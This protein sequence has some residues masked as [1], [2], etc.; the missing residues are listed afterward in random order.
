MDIQ[1]KLIAPEVNRMRRAQMMP[2]VPYANTDDASLV[3]A[4]QGIA[5]NMN[6]LSNVASSFAKLEQETQINIDNNALNLA[7]TNSRAFVQSFKPK[8]NDD[9]VKLEI[10]SIIAQQKTY[11]YNLTK[12]GLSSRAVERLNLNTQSLEE[13][14][15]IRQKFGRMELAE[16]QAQEI[17]MSNLD[18]AVKHGNPDAAEQ[19]IAE[20]EK[21]GY[22]LKQSRDEYISS[23]VMQQKI[24]NV[25]YDPRVD[26]R[27]LQGIYETL[28]DVTPEGQSLIYKDDKSGI[29][30]SA[31]DV[32]RAKSLVKDQINER[33]I[34]TSMNIDSREAKG[35]DISDDEYRGLFATGYISA[36][37]LETK[38]KSFSDKDIHQAE[39]KVLD[40]R[41]NILDTQFPINKSAK[42]EVYKNLNEE[43]DTTPMQFETKTELK[44]ML[45]KKFDGTVKE[46]DNF[47]L[48][49]DAMIT[50]AV[51]EMKGKAKVK[52]EVAW[53]FDSTME[54]QTEARL[55]LEEKALRQESAGL[56]DINQ[57]QQKVDEF[58][59]RVKKPV[60]IED[61]QNSLNRSIEQPKQII[62]KKTS[63]INYL[64][65]IGA[66]LSSYKKEK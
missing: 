8:L 52:K 45:K 66:D 12:T 25:I 7:E 33:I 16:Q 38:L 64:Q 63:M 30:M 44:K 32:R 51:S 17:T 37:M 23:A 22:R 14:L 35:E 10:S 4:T 40:L 43:I 20:A 53:W 56:K 48:A 55:K 57:I 28:D 18:N 50:K 36:K 61:F 47:T 1:Q 11:N 3:V 58:R 49:S 60:Y 27:Y 41:I 2:A 46:E 21:K 31:D 54:E 5:N 42:K 9:D 19:W 6:V 65:S 62:D 13:Q 29:K 59:T 24:G 15:S 39:D 34:T 26:V